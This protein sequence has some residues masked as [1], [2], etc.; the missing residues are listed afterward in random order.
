MDQQSAPVSVIIPCYRCAETIERAINS[1]CSQTQRPREV[2]LV[3]DFSNDGTLGVLH[4]L[5]GNYPGWIR[6][7]AL[8]FNG[9]AGSARNAGWDAASQPY[10]AFLDA[11]D[12]WHPGKIEI[13]YRWLAAHPEVALCGHKIAVSPSGANMEIGE[14]PPVAVRTSRAQWLLSCRFSTISVMMRGDLK[15]RFEAGKRH[16]EDYLLWMQIST[17]GYEV[18]ELQATLAYCFK[19]LY[20]AGGLSGNLWAMEA[21]ELDAYR[22]IHKD[23]LIS[24]IV[25]CGLVAMSLLKYLRRLALVFIKRG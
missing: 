23:G 1:L 13:Q 4:A 14:I 25:Y 2:I 24:G 15:F 19:P 20:G 10:I 17:S 3:D 11:D 22:R 16:A 21:G 9:G 8:P 6:V 18:W 5:R 12:A 7:I